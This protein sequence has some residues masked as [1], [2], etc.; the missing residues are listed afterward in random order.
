MNFP[1]TENPNDK[2]DILNYLNDLYVSKVTPQIN[3][4]KAGGYHNI[5]NNKD[6]TNKDKEDI[7]EINKK[8]INIPNAEIKHFSL[9]QQE[10]FTEYNES[11]TTSPR[12]KQSKQNGTGYNEVSGETK[13]Q[14]ELST[15]PSIEEVT[16]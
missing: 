7:L 1:Y 4:Q 5:H 12:R 6:E 9:R 11:E 16:I 2:F 8:R 3:I 15:T 10:D 14:R 13:Q